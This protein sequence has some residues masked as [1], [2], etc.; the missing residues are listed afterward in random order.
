MFVYKNA[1]YHISLSM[2]SVAIKLSSGCQFMTVSNNVNMLV[3]G[4][5]DVTKKTHAQYMKDFICMVLLP[6]S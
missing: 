4:S 3:N 1:C 2:S 6:I 5:L